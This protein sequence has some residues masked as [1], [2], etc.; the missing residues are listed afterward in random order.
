VSGVCEQREATREEAAQDL[1]YHKRAGQ[2]KDEGERA[3][4]RSPP[5]VVGAVG[6]SVITVMR[7]GHRLP[8]PV[9]SQGQ[10]DCEADLDRAEESHI[11]RV[12]GEEPRHSA[13]AFWASLP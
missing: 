8:F 1:G 6:V 13:G 2:G 7:V 4:V 5:V 10:P 3:T 9:L 12:V 11:V